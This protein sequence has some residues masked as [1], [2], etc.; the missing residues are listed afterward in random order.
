MV[1]IIKDAVSKNEI[2]ELL[3]YMSY[4]DHRTDRRPDVVSKHPRWD[5]DQWPQAIVKRILDQSLDYPYT[6]DEVIFNQFKISFRLHADSGTSEKQRQGSVILIPLECHGP[7][8]TV[9]FNNFW[10][11]GS[12]RFSKVEIKPFSYNLK[13][14]QGQ[15][16]TVDDIRILLDQ[17]LKSPNDVTDFSVTDEFIN[18]IKS[19]IAARENKGLTYADGRCYDYAE[20][21]NYDPNLLFDKDLQQSHLAHIP[22]E[23]LHGLT[24]SDIVEWIPGEAIV[25]ERTRIHAAGSGHSEKRGIT[26]FTSVV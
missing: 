19:A 16:Q 22:I 14:K 17:C 18:D 12:T 6:V 25:F 13:N 21:E 26:I 23:S 1:K 8:S 2:T 7:S 10:H 11:K 24:V 5:I 20:V 9:F 15:W 4:D 3:E